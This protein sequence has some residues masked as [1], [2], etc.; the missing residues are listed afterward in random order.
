MSLLTRSLTLGSALLQSAQAAY[1]TFPI[2]DT[3]DRPMDGFKDGLPAYIQMQL[4][5]EE[6]K[7]LEQFLLC[8]SC[9]ISY[10]FGDYSKEQI[11]TPKATEQMTFKEGA[12]PIPVN[13]VE[14]TFELKANDKDDTVYEVTMDIGWI[15]VEYQNS[16]YFSNFK[17]NMI[18]LSPVRTDGLDQALATQL[19]SRQFLNQFTQEG[20]QKDQGYLE[21]YA[22]DGGDNFILGGSQEEYEALICKGADR[23][24]N[25][26]NKGVTK[27]NAMPVGR[28]D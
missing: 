6:E 7:Q 10:I 21:S 1:L 15:S 4:Q 23:G 20:K 19:M 9:S 22:F 25:F 17:E 5:G 27:Q 3:T 28:N 18:G 26:E 13:F 12:K 14:T 2:Y 11:S 16:D 24:Y 8:T